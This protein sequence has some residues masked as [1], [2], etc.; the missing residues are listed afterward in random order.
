MSLKP[1]LSPA[2]LVAGWGERE[3]MSAG[4]WGRALAW[5]AAGPLT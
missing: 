3:R 5:H 1:S 2:V 4:G